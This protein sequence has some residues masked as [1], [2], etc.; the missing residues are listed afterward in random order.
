MKKT[1]FILLIV[2]SATFAVAQ[3]QKTQ[4]EVTGKILGHDGK[5]MPK[6]M[7]LVHHKPLSRSSIGSAE[8]EKDGSFHLTTDKTGVLFLQFVGVHHMLQTVTVMVEKPST[9]SLEVRLSVPQYKDD[10][11]DLALRV[12]DY[13]SH[14]CNV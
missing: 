12:E 6:A 8:A 11:P 7:V 3:V 2:L 14:G 10:F 13:N 4:T 5:P 9:V 1:S